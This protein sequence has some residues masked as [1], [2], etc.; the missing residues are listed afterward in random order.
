M[1]PEAKS[2]NAAPEKKAEGEVLPPTSVAKAENET[3]VPPEP[4]VPVSLQL[5]FLLDR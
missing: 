1:K 4:K 3:S 5:L 2:E